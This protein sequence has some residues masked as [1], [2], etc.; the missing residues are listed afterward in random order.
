MVLVEDLARALEVEV[1]LGGL[2]PGQ[3]QD[4]VEVAC[5]SR[6]TRPRPA[7]ASRAARA[8]ARRPS[9]ASSGRFF[10]SIC[11]RSSASSAC[12]SSPSPSSSWIAFSCWRRKYSRWPFSSS[13]WTCDW[14]F[15]PSSTTSSSRLRMRSTSRSR[16]ETSLCSSSACF[17]SVF[18]R[19]VEATRCESALGSSTLAAASSSS[20]GQVRDERDQAAELVLDAAGERLEL[21]RLL[22]LVGHD[23]ELADQVRVVLDVALELDAA[24]ALDEDPQRPVGDADHLVHDG[25]GAGLVEVVPAGLLDLGVLDGDERQHALALEHVV[26]ELDRALLADRERRDRLREDDRLLQRQ[27][28]QRRGDLDVCGL[29]RLFEVQFTHARP[30][31]TIATRSAC[32][33]SAAIGSVTI[34]MP[35]S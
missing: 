3:R 30:R 18:S 5:G 14:I 22:D 32:G 28:R 8:R 31:I 10:C 11:S 2:A 34:S 20:D 13:D 9:C 19:S 12:C 26:D 24:D 4:P 15:V 25:G 16:S 35:C 1:V 29:E 17:S 7:A 21:G 23:R 6:R 33:A 27:H